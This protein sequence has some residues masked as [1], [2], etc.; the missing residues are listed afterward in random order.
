MKYAGIFTGLAHTPQTKDDAALIWEGIDWDVRVRTPAIVAVADAKSAK[1]LSSLPPITNAE[2]LAAVV[3]ALPRLITT[4]RT[5]SDAA[6]AAS[7]WTTQVPNAG[8]IM[9]VLCTAAWAACEGS[10]HGL[11]WRTAKEVTDKSTA[12]LIAK[13]DVSVLGRF[14]ARTATW[15][16]F[17][18]S[19][20]KDINAFDPSVVKPI[21]AEALKAIAESRDALILNFSAPSA[22]PATVTTSHDATSTP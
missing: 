15:T 13:A 14:A 16:A 11:A 19:A 7:G 2:S 9:S 4:L 8:K 22:P 17:G 20:V 1:A 18:A 12:L 5:A 3:A 6:A 10:H 21:F